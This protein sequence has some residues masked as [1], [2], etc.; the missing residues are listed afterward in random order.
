VDD[1]NDNP[2]VFV[3]PEYRVR[4]LEDLPVGTVVGTAFAVDADAGNNGAV[5]YAI[6]DGDDGYFSVDRM[7]GVVRLTR[8]VGFNAREMFNLTI[9]AKDRAGAQSLASLTTMIVDVVPV[10]HNQH[11]PLFRDFVFQGRV[12]ENQP[13]GTSVMQLIATDSDAAS[14]DDYRVVYSI[15]NG[16]GLGRFSIDSKGTTDRASVLSPVATFCV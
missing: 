9:R 4:L 16:T 15:R 8:R 14:P 1:V 6:V 12:R 3:P 5:R 11:P 10:N 2:P 7:T 13:S